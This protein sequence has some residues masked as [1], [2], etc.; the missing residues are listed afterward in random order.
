MDQWFEG[1]GEYACIAVWENGSNGIGNQES[2]GIFELLFVVCC[3]FCYG[4]DYIMRLK[5]ILHTSSLHGG[6]WISC[7]LLCKWIANQLFIM[8][9][10]KWSLND[11]YTVNSFISV[12]V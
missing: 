11:L 12:H 4:R 2:N 6:K 10:V 7:Y 1:Y 9:P 3:E 8:L 5:Y